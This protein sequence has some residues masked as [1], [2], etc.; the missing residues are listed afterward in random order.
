[1]NMAKKWKE[2]KARVEND[3]ETWHTG[4]QAGIKKEHVAESHPGKEEVEP[5]GDAGRLTR[6]GSKTRR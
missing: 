2:K 5:H 1:M 4:K 6:H 3:G